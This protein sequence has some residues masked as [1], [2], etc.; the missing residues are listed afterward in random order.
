MNL[1][2]SVGQNSVDAEGLVYTYRPGTI[3]SGA[4]TDSVE[5]T[6]DVSQISKTTVFIEGMPVVEGHFSI[7]VGTIPCSRI[8]V[9]IVKK[10]KVPG[11]TFVTMHD[12][13]PSDGCEVKT[14]AGA[15][16]DLKFV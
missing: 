7:S 1:F 10:K 3:F 8:V 9:Q 2:L 4:W 16:Y 11:K 15:R 5:L 14:D 13:S 12:S 6:G